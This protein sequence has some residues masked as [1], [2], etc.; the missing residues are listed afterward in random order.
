M[1]CY[2]WTEAGYKHSRWMKGDLFQL[3][4]LGRGFTLVFGIKSVTFVVSRT[5][6]VSL[7]FL[8]RLFHAFLEGRWDIF[9]SK[10]IG[11]CIPLSLS[12]SLSLILSLSLNVVRICRRGRKAGRY[13]MKSKMP[14][15]CCRKDGGCIKIQIANAH[16]RSYFRL[17]QTRLA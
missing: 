9:C 12:L 5:C 1:K 2:M 14:W 16:A 17:P 10:T 3:E 15:Y 8:I 6:V 11:N 7:Y 13:L 4:D